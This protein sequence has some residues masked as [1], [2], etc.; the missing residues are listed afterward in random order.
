MS[1]YYYFQSGNEYVELTSG[2]WYQYMEDLEEVLRYCVTGGEPFEELVQ[3][4]YDRDTFTGFYDNGDFLTPRNIK[5]FLQP[6]Y[7]WA[8]KHP[9]FI[10]ISDSEQY[11][12]AVQRLCKDKGVKYTG[13]YDMAVQQLLETEDLIIDRYFTKVLS[14]YTDDKTINEIGADFNLALAELRHGAKIHRKS[15]P[16]LEYWLENGRVQWSYGAD[17]M[18]MFDGVDVMAE[19]WEYLGGKK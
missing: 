18:P 3:Q 12:M 10:L 7:H 19:D 13:Y 14:I 17:I 1:T 11:N 15:V 5:Y 6:L 9:D 8:Y 4:L 16:E 2:G